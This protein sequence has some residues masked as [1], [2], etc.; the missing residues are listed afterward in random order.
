VLFF[1]FYFVL[2]PVA[3][4]LIGSLNGS[5][6]LSRIFMKDDIRKHGSGNAGATNVLRTYGKGWTVLVSLWD[7]GKGVLTVCLPIFLGWNE[8]PMPGALYSPEQHIIDGF[9]V[10]PLHALLGLGVILGH[11]FPLY[12]GFKGGKGVLTSL[13]VM[14]LWDWQTACIAL[15]VF[16]LVVIGTRYISLGSIAAVLAMVAAA[17]VLQH[18]LILPVIVALLI[19]FLHRTN[20][21]RLVKGT[22]HKLG[23]KK[24]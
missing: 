2:P 7:L 6:L 18:D 15:A 9:P 16:F 20:M 8:N 14:L 10:V 24:S 4:Y 5:I 1:L 22:E 12:F 13:A 17:L 11:V 3:G 21:V 19:L 23:E